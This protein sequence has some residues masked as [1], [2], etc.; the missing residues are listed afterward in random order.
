MENNEAIQGRLKDLTEKSKDWSTIREYSQYEIGYVDFPFGKRK[1]AKFNE[2]TKLLQSS[3]G[4]KF[5]SGEIDEFVQKYKEHSELHGFD[6]ARK[7]EIENYQKNN[8]ISLDSKKEF[9]EYGFRYPAV[10]DSWKDSFKNSRGCDIT[11]VNVFAAKSCG[12]D[13]EVCDLNVSVPILKDV[14]LLVAYHVLEHVSDPLNAII[15]TYNSL[16]PGAVFHVEIPIE[17]DGPRLR[18]AHLFPFHSN[19]LRKMLEIA[20]FN[21]I[22]YTKTPFPGG[23][24][25][26]RAIAIK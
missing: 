5:Y 24:E 9:Y 12:Y 15:S 23:P 17:P 19:D 13:V 10:I 20:G 2:L 1:V 6:I 7:K 26:E 18:Y 14:S 4:V 22:F 3:R 11:D 16:S 21:I 8:L 25:I